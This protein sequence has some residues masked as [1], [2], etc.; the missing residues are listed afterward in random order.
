MSLEHSPKRETCNVP[1]AGKRL[2]LGPRA[3]Y[4]AARRGDLP[5]VQIGNRL[6][7]PLAA[8]DKLL[9]G[10]P[11]AQNLLREKKCARKSQN[12]SAKA[13]PEPQTHK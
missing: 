8:L 4:A 5:V 3:A 13:R 9:A 6:L 7:V 1:T 11:I 12:N 10:E 2:G